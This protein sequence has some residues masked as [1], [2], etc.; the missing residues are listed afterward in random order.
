MCNCYSSLNV[1]VTIATQLPWKHTHCFYNKNCCHLGFFTIKVFLILKNSI[2]SKVNHYRT[3]P[4]PLTLQKFIHDQWTILWDTW[5]L[6]TL[7]LHQ[8]LQYP[9]NFCLLKSLNIIFS[10][11]E[12]YLESIEFLGNLPWDLPSLMGVSG[13]SEVRHKAPH[14]VCRWH[15]P[16]QCRGKGPGK[17]NKR[18]FMELLKDKCKALCLGWTH[19]NAIGWGQQH[20]WELWRAWRPA[21]YPGSSTAPWQSWVVLQQNCKSVVTNPPRE[22]TTPLNS[23]HIYN[24]ACLGHPVQEKGQ[25]IL[26][27]GKSQQDGH[28]VA[29]HNLHEENMRALFLGVRRLKGEFIEKMEPD[30]LLRLPGRRMRSKFI[31]RNSYWI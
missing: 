22:A 18:N 19:W 29:A 30:P 26:N 4:V 9:S 6:K 8:A 25:K 13:T 16:E 12:N 3:F 11:P 14:Q 27:P 10:S 7:V 5:C 20:W 2:L 31:P 23:A 15:H 28:E 17:W 24:P 21:G 1:S